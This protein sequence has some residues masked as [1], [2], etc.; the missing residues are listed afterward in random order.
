MHSLLASSNGRSVSQQI[1]LLPGVPLGCEIG[2]THQEK[3]SLIKGVS[4][5]SVG[6]SIWA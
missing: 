6:Q 1:I 4:E 3:T 2:P 5:Q